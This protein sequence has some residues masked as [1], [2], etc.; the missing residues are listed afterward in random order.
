M[1]FNKHAYCLSEKVCKTSIDDGTQVFTK[2]R[3]TV[4]KSL[5][6]NIRLISAIQSNFVIKCI[7]GTVKN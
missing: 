2:A 7:V 1:N 6:V 3:I 5:I 4:V